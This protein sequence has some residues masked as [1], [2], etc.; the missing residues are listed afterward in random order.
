MKASYSAIVTFRYLDE[1]LERLR[2]LA[3]RHLALLFAMCPNIARLMKKEICHGFILALNELF[4]L[5]RPE[6]LATMRQIAE[7]T[8]YTTPIILDRKKVGATLSKSGQSDTLEEELC[9]ED[10]EENPYRFLPRPPS[11]AKSAAE[12]AGPL[13]DITAAQ[14]LRKITSSH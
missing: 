14:A 5:S 7:L 11:R 12:E 8:E 2:D 1:P 10:S 4:G 9:L 6:D 13:S 3:K